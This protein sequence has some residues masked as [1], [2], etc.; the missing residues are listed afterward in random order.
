MKIGLALGSGGARGIAHIA[1][2]EKLRDLGVNPSVV[3]GSSA[4]A[5]IGAFYS[6]FGID[7][8]L[9]RMVEIADLNR[10]LIAKANEFMGRKRKLRDDVVEM[11]K[12]IFA[13]SL[14]AGDA[15]YNSLARLFGSHRFSDCKT[16]FAVTTFDIEHGKTVVIDEGFI[17]DAVVASSS[18]PGAFPPV[19]L[20]GMHLVDGGTTR[21]VPVKESKMYGADFIVASDVSAFDPELST[22]FALQYTVD[23]IKGKII[24]D[25]DLQE[26]DMAVKFK[27][28]HIQWYEFNKSKII[29]R[30]AKKEL[31]NVDF[32]TLLRALESK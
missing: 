13:H 17:L 8:L 1:L 25:L 20:G 15:M 22:M 2:L 5:V 28:P 9:E 3:V 16:R 30:M 21:V 26:A 31:E 32:T 23:D 24:A 18:V 29:Y 4:G 6:L 11:S 14:L 10:K 27:I 7:G 19:R 12:I